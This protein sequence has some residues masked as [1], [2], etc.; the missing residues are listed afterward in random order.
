MTW[1]LLAM[2]AMLAAAPPG[3]ALPVAAQPSAPDRPA[4]V[5]AREASVLYRMTQAGTA[6]VEV[7]ITTR[8]GGSP[9]RIDMPDGAYMLV[10]Q[11]ARSMALVVP[12]EQMV[13][14]L[15]FQ[16]GPQAQFQLNERM[17]FTRKGIDTVATVHCT[18]WDIVLDKARGT[19]CISDEGV[20]LRSSGQDEA[21][22]RNLI[23]AISVSFAPAAASEFTPPP[24][25]D[26]IGAMPNG[27]V[28]AITQGP[29][30]QGP[31]PAQ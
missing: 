28:P 22:R 16:A 2:L 18:N 10:D 14:D 23:E 26:R 24:D 9:M 21:G 17:R 27:P 15:P 19:M 7:R 20:M 6:P 4:M 29:A 30:T 8:A 11:T 25:F 31:A 13:M 12:T 5:P 1:P 3:T